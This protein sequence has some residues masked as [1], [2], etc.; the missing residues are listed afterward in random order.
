MP[1]ARALIVIA[2]PADETLYFHQG[3]KNLSKNYNVDILCL[4]FS[5]FSDQGKEFQSLMRN[6]GITV[7][8]KNLPITEDTLPIKFYSYLKA[9]IKTAKYSLVVSYS[10]FKNQD[11]RLYQLQCSFACDVICRKL[12]I[13]YGFFSEKPLA[14]QK[15]TNTALNFNIQKQLLCRIS[16]ISALLKAQVNKSFIFLEIVRSLFY[17]ATRIFR[18]NIFCEYIFQPRLFERHSDLEHYKSF[19]KSLVLL[20]CY[21]NSTEY[22]YLREADFCIVSR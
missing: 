21:L 1:T 15:G 7:I 10:P 17:F 11:F 19:I 16:Y 5:S 13:A 3:L 4:T 20:N 22:F 8:F 9:F 6:L 12:K 14:P 18:T 2:H